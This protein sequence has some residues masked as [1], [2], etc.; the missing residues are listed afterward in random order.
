MHSIDFFEFDDHIHMLTWDDSEPEPIVSDGIYEMSGVTL[1][2]QMPVPFRLVPEAASIQ[3]V[4]VK[5]LIFPYYSVQTPFVLIP[6]VNEVQAPY[7]DDVHISDVHYVI[8][9]GRVSVLQIS[10]SDDD[11]LLTGFTFDKVQTI[12]MEDFC[13]DFVAMSFDQHSSTVVLDMMRGMSYLP[14]MGLGRRQHGPSEFMP[15]PEHDEM[16]RAELT[17]TPF[18]YP[19]RP[20]TLSLTGYFVRASEPQLRLSDEAP[21]TSTSVLVAS[22]S[23]DRLSLMAL[24]YPDEI[25]EHGTFAEIGDIMDRVVPRDDVDE[26]LTMSL[27]QIEEIAHPELASPFDLFGVFAI[28]IAE[29]IQTAPTPEIVEDVIVIDGLFDGPIVLVEEASDFVDPHLSFDVLSRF[30]SRHDDVSDSSSMDL[31]IFDM[32]QM[33]TRRLLLISDPI[34]QRVSPAIEDTKVVDFDTAD[35][36]R[37]LRIGS[38]LSTDERDSLIQLLRSYLNIFAWS[39]EDTPGLDPS[40]IQHLKGEIQKQ[41]SVGF[42]LVVKYLEWLANVIPVPKKDG[43]VRVCFD[44]RDLNKANPKDDF[45]LP[46]ID[47]LVDST[48][49]HSMLSF[50][51]GFFWYSQ[52]L[53]APEDMEKTSFITEWDDMIVKSRDRSNHL[54]AL[55]RFFDKIRRFRLRLN[56]KKCT[57]GVTSRKLLGYMGQPTAWDDHCQRA[58]ERI[59]EYLF[60]TSSFGTFY[61]RDRAI[62]YLSKRMLD[63]ETRYVMIERYCL[64]LVWATRR[65]RHYMTE[66]SVHLISRLDPLRYLFDRPALIGRLM[67]WLVLLTE[68]DIHYVTQKSIR[69]SIVA[70][71]LA[72]LLVS[73]GRV[74]DDDFPDEDIAVVTS[75]SGWHINY[76]SKSALL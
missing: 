5:P 4:I 44:F 60:V 31:S 63:Y 76:Y 53:M 50:M 58:F 67:R 29:E 11:L 15:F 24:C 28:E 10:H 17:H 52:I 68:F 62:Y 6:D 16:V 57:F 70:D 38:D 9:D 61:T 32:I 14:G 41:P 7:V 65:L 37:E 13:R 56:P 1:G 20:Y 46:H 66:Y 71:H 75:L 25:D 39:Y 21:D 8:R 26:M 59:R 45:P 55:E 27:S 48:T 34:D 3:T 12:E 23:P 54:S 49:G 40:I 51:D 18:D 47:M 42:L 64:A 69:E 33:M 22:S 2:P 30:V 19:V 35:Q 74:I 73:N 43:K 36:P 72:S